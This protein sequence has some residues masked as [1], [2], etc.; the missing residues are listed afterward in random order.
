M[1][2]VMRVLI[3]KEKEM[4]VVHSQIINGKPIR[5]CGKTIK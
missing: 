5:E 4:D 1:V 3:L 2:H